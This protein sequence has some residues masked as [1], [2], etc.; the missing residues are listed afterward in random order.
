MRRLNCQR[1]EFC[2]NMIECLD[3]ERHDNCADFYLFMINEIV[4][5]L[6]FKLKICKAIQE[7]FDSKNLTQ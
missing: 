4:T 3:Q 2:G 5:K 6:E 7:S 1:C